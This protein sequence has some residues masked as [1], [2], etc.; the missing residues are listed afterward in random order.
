MTKL[1][2]LYRQPEDC[3][4][5]DDHYYGTHTPIVKKIPGLRKTEVTKIIGSPRGESP[6]YLLCEMYFDDEDSL[7]HAMTSEEMKASS[8][9]LMSFAGELVTMMVGEEVHV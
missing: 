6:Y 7:N 5:F 2:A 8:K 9:D 1:I 3:K 4:K